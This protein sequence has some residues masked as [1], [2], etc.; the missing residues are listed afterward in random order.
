MR[1][2]KIIYQEQGRGKLLWFPFMPSWSPREEHERQQYERL[3]LSSSFTLVPFSIILHYMKVVFNSSFSHVCSL[4][5]QRLL[6]L[7][8]LR[9]ISQRQVISYFC[10]IT[11]DMRAQKEFDHFPGLSDNLGTYTHVIIYILSVM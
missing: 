3:L 11:N 4:H 1:I 10:N 7:L 9:K 8:I 5:L 6:W 2:Y